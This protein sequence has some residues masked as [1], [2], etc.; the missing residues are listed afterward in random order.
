[1]DAE[2]STKEARRKS[3]I[4]APRATITVP[5]N[6]KK[7]HKAFAAELT[8][9]IEPER[10]NVGLNWR[11]P[12]RAFIVNRLVIVLST[13]LFKLSTI[14]PSESSKKCKDLQNSH[15]DIYCKDLQRQL[16]LRK[17]LTWAYV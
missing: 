14:F 11:K 13:M 4:H 5:D 3:S 15:K 2:I 1:M 10:S 8:W 9:W 12:A 6:K 17:L 7:A 16:F